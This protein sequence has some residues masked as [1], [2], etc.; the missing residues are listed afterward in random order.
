MQHAAMLLQSNRPL[1]DLLEQYRARQISR[2]DMEWQDRVMELGT[3]TPTELSKL[4]GLLLAN[5][6]V[7]TRV[8]AD[9]FATAG[10]LTDCYK[11]TRDGLSALRR[12]DLP[13]LD[14]DEAEGEMDGGLGDDDRAEVME[15]IASDS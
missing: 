8:T 6:W 3:L 2:P 7:D 4:H 15:E 13:F 11:V 10:K 9:A 12:A 5:G 1:R 14:G